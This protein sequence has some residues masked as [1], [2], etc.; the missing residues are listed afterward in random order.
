MLEQPILQSLL[1]A[2]KRYFGYNSAKLEP[3]W[4]NSEHQ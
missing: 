4:M 3:I 1:G 2:M